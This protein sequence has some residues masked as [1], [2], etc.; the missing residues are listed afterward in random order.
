MTRFRKKPVEVEAVQWTG[1]NRE[2]LEASQAAIVTW[3]RGRIVGMFDISPYLRV[4]HHEET[5]RADPGDW[6]V[7]EGDVFGVYSPLIFE[8]TYEP[9]G[10]GVEETYTR[11][12]L[13]SQEAVKLLAERLFYEDRRRLGSPGDNALVGVTIIYSSDLGQEDAE[14]E[15]LELAYHAPPEHPDC[16]VLKVFVFEAG[17]VSLVGTIRNW[18]LRRRKVRRDVRPGYFGRRRG[19]R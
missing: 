17:E 5:E 3:S 15:L 8:A 18:W 13:L 9:A 7:K 6:I 1:E 12:Q 11:E 10:Q 19:A 16:T 14:D 4:P 2:E